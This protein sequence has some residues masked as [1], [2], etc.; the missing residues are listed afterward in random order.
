MS[1]TAV[2]ANTY[3]V[4]LSDAVARY[5]KRGYSIPEATRAAHAIISS[6]FTCD[7]ARAIVDQQ[8]DLLDEQQGDWTR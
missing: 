3:T 8:M 5:R 4:L 7:S 2:D 1:I 6:C